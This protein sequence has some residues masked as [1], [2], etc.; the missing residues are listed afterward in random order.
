MNDLRKELD[1]FNI[2]LDYGGNQDR[3]KDKFMKMGGCAA[4]TAC[5][6]CI[7]LSLYKGKDILYPYDK[8]SLGQEDYIRFTNIMKPYLHPR[9]NGIDRLE[10]YLDG[11]GAYLRDAGETELTMEALPGHCDLKEAVFAVKEQIDG[12]L[13]APCLVLKHQNP[14]FRDY[15]WH[16]FL[17]TGYEQT[18]EN[19]MVKAVT[20]GSWQWMNFGEL[21]DTG[22]EKKGGLI[23]YRL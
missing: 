3:L 1:Y 23:L 12:G 15:V 17:L 5:D 10:I 4:V 20:Y 18:E 2:G 8:G 21:W 19:L 9:I 16:W 13:L 14:A 11:M 22:Y 7:Y 6:S